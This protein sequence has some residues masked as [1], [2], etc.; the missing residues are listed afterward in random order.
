[1]TTIAS[2]PRPHNAPPSPE[3]RFFDWVDGIEPRETTEPRASGRGPA[4]AEDQGQREVMTTGRWVPAAISD[5]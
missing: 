3:G 2:R 4:E 5:W 1:M